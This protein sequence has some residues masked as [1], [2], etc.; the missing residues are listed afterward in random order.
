MRAE[1]ASSVKE[2]KSQRK[3]NKYV[4]NVRQ[5]QRDREAVGG[6]ELGIWLNRPLVVVNVDYAGGSPRRSGEA[7]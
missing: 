4:R 2:R 7:A 5:P 1:A 6:R 3:M